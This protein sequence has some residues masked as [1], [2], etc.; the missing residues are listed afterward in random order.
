M[1]N[2]SYKT[3]AKNNSTSEPSDNFE[4][5]TLNFEL[6]LRRPHPEQLARVAAQHTFAFGAGAFHFLNF[7]GGPP[8][9]QVER[10]VGADHDVVGA[11]HAFQVFDGFDPVDQIV[12]VQILQ[13]PARWKIGG[14]RGRTR[15]AGFALV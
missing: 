10:V 6:R 3:L 8:V 4:P 2:F 13:I 15:A 1:A 12:E 5:G 14:D 11:D 9:A 7:L